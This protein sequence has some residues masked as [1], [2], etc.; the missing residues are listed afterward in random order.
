M[1]QLEEK[2]YMP[3]KARKAY[4]RAFKGSSLVIDELANTYMFAVFRYSDKMRICIEN[5]QI[6]MEEVYII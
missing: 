1:D 4:I 5:Y 3:K 6:T 2:R